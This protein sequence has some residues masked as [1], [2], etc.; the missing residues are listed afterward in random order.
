[1][2][3]RSNLDTTWLPIIMQK[4][5][6]IGKPYTDGELKTIAGEFL[7]RLPQNVDN[8]SFN[9]ILNQTFTDFDNLKANRGA[10]VQQ[11]QAPQQTTQQ[12]IQPA[13][14]E[15]PTELTADQKAEMALTRN[16]TQDIRAFIDQNNLGDKIGDSSDVSDISEEVVNRYMF[17][18]KKVGKELSDKQYLRIIRDV[19]R[20][21]LNN[22]SEEQ[23]IDD[24]PAE[25][26]QEDQSEQQDTDNDEQETQT[27]EKQQGDEQ[28]PA[29]TEEEQ[30]ED[31]TRDP[32][33]GLTAAQICKVG[34]N[35]EKIIRNGLKSR[36]GYMMNL[37]YKIVRDPGVRLSLNYEDTV[38]EFKE[39]WMDSGYG[40]G[41]SDADVE[42]IT[43]SNVL[44][45][46]VL[47]ERVLSDIVS[48]IRENP[49]FR[50][51]SGL[52]VSSAAIPNMAD[53]PYTS[54]NVRF[55]QRDYNGKLVANVGVTVYGGKFRPLMK[56]G[57]GFLSDIFKM[58][59]D[60]ANRR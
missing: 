40:D 50:G 60:L 20:E 46:Y 55:S 47:K 14:E 45:I 35:L 56:S 34:D 53:V 5:K 6:R 29:E 57:M 25:Q 44:V 2:A 38:K 26:A 42:K 54:M 7:K 32:L 19:V 48:L 3:P 28:Q 10:Q 16:F 51:N 22:E 30:Q 37:D 8:N 13:K 31:E 24:N 23:A 15:K 36:Y 33:T 41:F 27:E 17:Y 49:A 21:K 12:S 4:A 52:A 39:S 9:E 59:T 43:K 18:K 58:T 1:M 11:P